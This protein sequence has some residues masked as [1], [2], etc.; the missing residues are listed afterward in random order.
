MRRTLVMLAAAAGAVSLLTTGRTA[1]G[2]TVDLI[3]KKF[4]VHPGA[5]AGSGADVTVTAQFGKPMPRITHWLSPDS[6]SVFTS[7]QVIPRSSERTR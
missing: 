1:N 4:Q 7:V 6:P 2:R 5:V 3:V